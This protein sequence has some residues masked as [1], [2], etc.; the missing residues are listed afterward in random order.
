MR[1]AIGKQR[2]IV[3]FALSSLLRRKAKNGALLSVFTVIVFTLA[4]VM[5]FTHSLKK[6]AAFLLAASPDM[7]VQRVTAGRQDMVPLSYLEK[8]RAIKGVSSVSGRLWG[9]YFDPV[10]RANYTLLVS[11]DR[12]MPQGFIAVGNG[13]ARSRGLI[14]GSE[15]FFRQHDGEPLGLVIKGTFA[16]SSELMTADL[17][18][19]AETDF[20]RLSGIAPGYVNDLMVTVRNQA[21]RPTAARKI[22]EALPDSRPLIK[23]EL[24]RTYDSVFDWRSGMIVVV[25]STAILAFAILAWEKAS[26]LGAEERREIGVLKAVGWETY[27]VLLLKLWESAIISSLAFLG[28]VIMAYLHV[29]LA[30]AAIFGQALKGWSVLYPRFRLS[31]SIEAYQLVTLFFLT[32]VPY[33]AATLIPCWRAA[34]VDPDLVMRSQ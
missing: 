4:S 31:P 28:G 14:T 9:Y 25:L 26:G 30:D 33:A 3:D 29:F 6:E 32:V 15:V 2:Y 19:M 5:F 22:T 23:E 18:L 8:V 27:D 1:G 16:E 11:T 13:I 34:T 20:R 17:I 12:P 21:E 10:S 7:I 24:A